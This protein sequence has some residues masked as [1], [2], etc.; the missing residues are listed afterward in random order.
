VRLSSGECIQD[1]FDANVNALLAILFSWGNMNGAVSSNI[2]RAKDAPWFRLG[3]IV[4]LVYIVIGFVC[5]LIFT[6]GIK[7]E[8]DARDAG[9]RDELIVSDV[10]KV[11]EETRKNAKGGVYATIDDARRDKGDRWSGYR[12]RL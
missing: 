1:P 7:R 3:H 12:Y 2:Y 6:W 5:T 9:L 11:D 10:E 8:N 4:V